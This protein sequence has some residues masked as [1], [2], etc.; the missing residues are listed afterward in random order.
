MNSTHTA[1]LLDYKTGMAN[2]IPTIFYMRNVAKHRYKLDDEL[3]QQQV[4]H[5]LRL[6]YYGT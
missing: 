1:K 4:V 2:M 6:T 5:S 3:Q